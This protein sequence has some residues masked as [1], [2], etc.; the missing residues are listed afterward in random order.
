[1]NILHIEDD[2]IYQKR[3]KEGLSETVKPFIKSCTFDDYPE[4]LTFYNIDLI[5]LDLRKG[6]VGDEEPGYKIIDEIWETAFCPII[7]FSAIADQVY[8]NEHSEN[9][10]IKKVLKGSGDVKRLIDAVIELSGFVEHKNETS[11]LLNFHISETYKK[12]FPSILNNISNSGVEETYDIFVR[13]I[14]R[15]IAAAID[16]SP[17]FSPIKSWEIYLLPPISEQLLTTDILLKKNEDINKAESYMIVL[18]PSCDLQKDEEKDRKPLKMVLVVSCVS[19]NQYLS[20]KYLS[21]STPEDEFLKTLPKHISNTGSERFLPLPG[22][23]GFIPNMA[24][25]FKR[26]EMIPYEHIGKDK[27]YSR[28]ASID[29]PF[30]EAIIWAHMQINCRPGLPDRNF[31]LWTQQIWEE[32]NK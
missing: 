17:D 24:C 16:E 8:P 13:L 29:S 6:Q 31:D 15:R 9:Y 10:F 3:V 20:Y 1:M 22:L 19:I 32:I 12:V 18:S 25:D 30:R 28:I 7:V 5:I 21:K 23:K 27:E 14:R 4:Y 26:L 2:I 11:K